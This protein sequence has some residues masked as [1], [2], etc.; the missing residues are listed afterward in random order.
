MLPLKC[1][2]IICHHAPWITAELNS[3]LKDL[4]LA[5]MKSE[6]DTSYRSRYKRL[7]SNVI[8]NLRNRVQKNYHNLVDEAQNNPTAMWKTI[9]KVLHKKSSPMATMKIMLKGT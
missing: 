2:K 4:D 6:K 3:L 5:K 9:N 1:I 7:R 8:Y